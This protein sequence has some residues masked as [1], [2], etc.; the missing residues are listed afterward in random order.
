MIQKET[1]TVELMKT[2]RDFPLGGATP[3]TAPAAPGPKGNLILGVMPEFNR[4]TLAFIEQARDYGDVVRMR[5]FYLTVHFLYNPAHIEYVLSTNAKNFIKSRSL[6]TPFFRRLVGNGL[7]TSEG[8]EWK[9]QRRLAQPA[10]HRQRISSYGDVMVEYADRMISGWRNDE[11]RDIHRDMMRL[12]LEVVV[13]TLFNA[14]I[15][16][17]AD[18]VGRVL[19]RMVKP[20]A[21]QAT[22]KWIL[23]NRLPTPTNRRFNAD[24]REIDN[25][26]Y[27]L[28]A[29]RRSSGADQGDLLSMLLA[30]QD[31]DGSQMTDHQLRDEVMTLF[32]AGHE[33]TALTL[34]W[35]WYL[36]AQNPEVE[37]NFHAELDEVLEGRLPTVADM[38]RLKYTEKIAKESMRLY[39][40]AY[41]VGREAIQ[42][43]ELGGYR[44]P[45][46]AQLF[47]FQ[48]VTQR[49][50][51]FFS[52]PNRFY[53]ERW[54]EEL[55]NSLPKYAYFPFGGG[56][57][58][59]IGN[60]FAMME[61]VLL[62]ATIGQRFRFSLLPDHQVSLMPAMSLRP[63]GGIPVRVAPRRVTNQ[64][65][66]DQ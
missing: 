47:M 61:V 53:P 41:G 15:S 39:P 46:R 20:F 1:G 65:N 8:E 38:P 3:A 52:E 51:R 22:L 14:D 40:P 54:T 31:E 30:A 48:W 25:I 19:A 59:C 64:Q 29:E 63:A 35:A 18:K 45:A 24:A 62:L 23:D 55:T 34:S 44:I 43:F 60:Y 7:L 49:D 50:S 66:E 6:R 36:L 9:R 33:T 37:K 16:G 58:A 28:I 42:E 32:L 56:P 5:F 10:F 12:T 57:R 27:R 13:K 4:D 21:S 11:V 26:V 17:E 2:T